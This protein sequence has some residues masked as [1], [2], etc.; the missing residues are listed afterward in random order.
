MLKSLIQSEHQRILLATGIGDGTVEMVDAMVAVGASDKD[1][2]KASDGYSTMQIVLFDM[3][4]MRG[5][6]ISEQLSKSFDEPY[7]NFAPLWIKS[8]PNF[9]EIAAEDMGNLLQMSAHR[10]SFSHQSNYL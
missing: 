3:R 1:I 8:L 10:R 7:D 2:I 4:T 9:D 5:V 6:D